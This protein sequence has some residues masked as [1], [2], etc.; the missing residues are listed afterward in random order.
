VSS[1]ALQRTLQP[2]KAANHAEPSV[3]SML[4]RGLGTSGTPSA[5]VE[6]SINTSAAGANS[7]SDVEADVTR[8]RRMAARRRRGD[9]A[10]RRQLSSIQY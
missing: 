1:R 7:Q 4:F 3:V 8:A 2:S 10:A 9:V 5:A 6:C